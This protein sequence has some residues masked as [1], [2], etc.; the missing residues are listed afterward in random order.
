MTTSAE[1]VERFGRRTAR[2][3]VADLPECIAAEAEESIGALEAAVYLTTLEQAEL[4]PLPGGRRRR[5]LLVAG[6]TAGRA[7]TSGEP[8]VEGPTVWAP[9]LVD[10]DRLGVL[11]VALADDPT[12][13]QVALVV[14]LARETGRVLVARGTFSDDVAVVRR[15]QLPTVG[16]ELLWSVLPPLTC[17]AGPV[18]ISALLEPTYSGGGDGFD[19][20]VNGDRVHLAVLDTMGHG[21][22]AAVLTTTAIA[23]YRHS[24]RAGHGLVETHTAL[25]ALLAGEAADG[26]F[27]TALLA[28]LDTTTGRLTWLSA[29]HPAPLVV[30]HGG[31]VHQPATD[32]VPPLGVG[33]GGGEP[34]VAED[35]LEPGDLVCLYTDGLTEARDLAGEMVG[36][37]GLAALLRREA[38][39]DRAVPEV[40]R[41]LRDELM[42]DDEAWMSDD[43]T[44]LL[45]R[46]SGP[47]EGG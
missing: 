45:L 27:A 9:V 44:A 4:V 26:R 5:T 36:E 1:L 40:V 20:A 8:A 30:R 35:Y 42:A 24:R 17:T 12:E 13:E 16:A 3:R 32:P 33:L 10:G 11:E 6:S 43:A 47:R 22:G 25:E 14:A 23:A 41:A 29:G 18:A 21:F 2:G 7:L 19:Y 31:R 46:W 39:P 28:E 38:A 34:A 15:S 37:A